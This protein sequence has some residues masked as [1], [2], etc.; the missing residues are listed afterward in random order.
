MLRRTD[1]AG[2]ALEG[3]AEWAEDEGMHAFVQW[4][5][6]SQGAT[7]GGQSGQ[8]GSFTTHG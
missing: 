3:E 2:S 8:V 7:L 6:S 1:T 4:V 5:E